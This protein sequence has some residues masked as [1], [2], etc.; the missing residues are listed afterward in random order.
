MD[1]VLKQ[2]MSIQNDIGYAKIAIEK[3]KVLVNDLEQ[4]FFDLTEKSK[5]C[6]YHKLFGVKNNIVVDYI[7]MANKLLE[8]IDD[9]MDEL[10]LP[11]GENVPVCEG[12]HDLV[13]QIEGHHTD[14]RFVRLVLGFAEKLT[15]P[16][17]AI[18][19]GN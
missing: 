1:S 17:S 4:D 19:E 6:Y 3:A 10:Y 16:S 8:S 12:Y 11:L 14:E 2:L 5:I 18:E 9:R 15:G 13:A 7:V